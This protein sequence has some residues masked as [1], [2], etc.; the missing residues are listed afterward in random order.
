MQF[1]QVTYSFVIG[2]ALHWNFF[3][4][5]NNMLFILIN[6]FHSFIHHSFDQLWSK[7]AYFIKFVS[8]E[9]GDF[10][11]FFWLRGTIE[12]KKLLYFR[13]Q[14]TSFVWF[15]QLFEIY[16]INWKKLKH[17]DFF[18]Y[19]FYLFENFDVCS[20]QKQSQIN[21][22]ILNTLIYA[23]KCAIVRFYRFYYEWKHCTRYISRRQLNK[24]VD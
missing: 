12:M 17:F 18:C 5:I 4:K 19:N 9:M 14:N 24:Y 8:K 6:E 2:I 15:E 13:I 16:S 11:C 1:I 10:L 7:S 3:K 23:N 21:H 22:I 20:S